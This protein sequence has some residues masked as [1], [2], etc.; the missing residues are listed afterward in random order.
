MK[1]RYTLESVIERHGEPVLIIDVDTGE[2]TR[3]EADICDYPCKVA[4]FKI[5]KGE[6]RLRIDG[7][8]VYGQIQENQDK[9]VPNHG[10]R[11]VIKHLIESCS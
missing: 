7:Y 4:L 11:F 8:I 2:L 6:D 9:W 1:N 10:E 3:A 5:K